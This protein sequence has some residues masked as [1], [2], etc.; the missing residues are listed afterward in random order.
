MTSKSRITK[1]CVVVDALGPAEQRAADA[2]EAGLLAEL[3]DDRLGQ[4]LAGL[5]PP[6]GHR[7][8]ALR[9][10]AAPAD[11]EQPVVVDD[12]GADADDRARAVTTAARCT[13]MA[14]ATSPKRLEEVLGV[15]GRR[16]GPGCR[17]RSSPARVHQ[18]T[19]GLHH[20]L[21][22]PSSRRRARRRGR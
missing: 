15:R 13:T 3:A 12:D 1:W 22:D 4:R 20:D 16:A 10:A 21:A 18:S 2:L 7:P 11:E 6:A 5:D 19:S 17:R 9:R 8:L 14:R